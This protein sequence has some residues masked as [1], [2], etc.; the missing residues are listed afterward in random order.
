MEARGID[1]REE[2]C[3]VTSVSHLRE[4]IDVALLRF[5]DAGFEFNQPVRHSRTGNMYET[6]GLVLQEA[7]LVPCVIY[8]ADGVHWSRPLDEF[9]DKFE[10]G[11][12]Q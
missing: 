2:G 3:E 10:V 5:R 9:L 12:P 7:T 4:T 6:L 8:S 1:A 11:V